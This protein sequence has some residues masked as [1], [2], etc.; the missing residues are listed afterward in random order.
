MV[1]QTDARNLEGEDSGFGYGGRSAMILFLIGLA[2]LACLLA[3]VRPLLRS[4]FFQRAY[5]RWLFKGERF[6]V[7]YA[8][9]L[10]WMIFDR[11]TVT[12]IELSDTTRLSP[13]N[14]R[15]K[16]IHEARR[17]NQICT[18]SRYKGA[19]NWGKYLRSQVGAVGD[20]GLP[21]GTQVYIFKSSLTPA[22]VATVVAAEQLIT[23]TGI[24]VGDVLLM[25]CL[26]IAIATATG[27]GAARVSAVN[28]IGLTFFNPTAGGL[29]P[30]PGIYNVAVMRG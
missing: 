24:L 9:D 27:S 2:M 21:V 15:R 6:G 19:R 30:T 23:L 8:G 18:V 20:L 17:M 4:L 5:L 10:R 22:I 14:Q 26:Q 28:Q 12:T 7:R 25:A 29:T 13:D 3:G 1:L 16:L 11:D